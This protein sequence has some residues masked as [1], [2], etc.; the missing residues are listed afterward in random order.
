[1]TDITIN[2]Y[3]LRNTVSLLDTFSE[4]YSN[5]ASVIIPADLVLNFIRM[6]DS[7]IVLPIKSVDNF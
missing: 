3:D 5:N 4:A 6:F 2:T 1:M 7:G